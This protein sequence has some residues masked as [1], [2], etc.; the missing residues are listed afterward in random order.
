MSNILMM[1]SPKLFYTSERLKD[2]GEKIILYFDNSS[3]LNC[4]FD[5]EGEVISSSKITRVQYEKIH[6][7][8]LKNL[9]YSWIYVMSSGMEQFLQIYKG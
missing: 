8:E 2:A 6:V 3:L 1:E 9:K 5:S 7:R 4:E